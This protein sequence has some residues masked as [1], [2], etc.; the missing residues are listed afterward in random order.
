MVI[1]T[2]SHRPLKLILETSHKNGTI[3]GKKVCF[4]VF[5]LPLNY[6]FNLIALTPFLVKNKQNVNFRMKCKTDFSGIHQH[7]ALFDPMQLLLKYK[8]K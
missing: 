5:A 8:C 2:A 7:L 1:S 3:L 4:D 6:G